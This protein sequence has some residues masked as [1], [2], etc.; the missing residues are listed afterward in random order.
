MDPTP[1]IAP[2][3]SWIIKSRGAT[4]N[5]RVPTAQQTDPMKDPVADDRDDEKAAAGLFF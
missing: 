1:K 3:D 5:H 2:A 4:N